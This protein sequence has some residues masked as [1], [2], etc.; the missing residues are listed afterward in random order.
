MLSSEHDRHKDLTQDRRLD[1]NFCNTKL[2]TS[3]L[4]AF[5]FFVGS[6]TALVTMATQ[7]GAELVEIDVSSARFTVEMA[8]TA[9]ER[10]RGLMFR[11]SLP[12]GHGMLFVEP[13]VAEVGFWMKNMRISLDILYF[14]EAGRLQKMY[15]SVP[16]CRP[17][18]GAG[19]GLESSRCPLYRSHQPIKYVLELS[20]GTAS[21]LGLK[22]GDALSGLD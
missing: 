12:A 3:R 2:I 22:V 16:P 13:V 5:R 20:A 7:G 15:E 17:S 14:D 11:D 4:R 21:K 18:V 8:V 1:M 6:I 10:R 19:Q 9:E